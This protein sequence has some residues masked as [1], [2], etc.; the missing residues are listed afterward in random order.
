MTPRKFFVGRAIGLIVLLG[1]VGLVGAFYWVNGYIYDQKQGYAPSDYKDAEYIID[2]TRIRL[3]DGVA[4]VPAAP[5]S[6][7]TITTRYFGNGVTRDLNGDGREDVAFILTQD[8]GGTGVFYYVVAALNTERGYVGS[9]GLL[10]GDRIAPQTMEIGPGKSIIVNYADRAPG[11]DFAAQPSVGKSMRLIL[12]PNYMQFGEVA[13]NF[14]GEADP[15]VMKLDMHAWTWVSALY[16]D[17]REIKP[18]QA[19]QFTLAFGTDGRFSAATDCNSVAGS[20]TT[21]SDDQITFSDMVSTRMF[22]EGSQESEFT[23]LL[24]NTA[25]YHFTSRGELVLDLKADSGTV[26]FR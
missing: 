20:Y 18:K 24:E 2:G 21:A 23:A 1:I 7:S 12:D 6:A 5:G 10:L 19:G 22:C 26:T 13:Q 16:N 25:S 8:G 15:N 9:E 11:E 3:T 4:E 17:G 14:E